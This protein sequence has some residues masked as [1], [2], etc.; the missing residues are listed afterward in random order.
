MTEIAGQREGKAA[1]SK[2]RMAC[3]KN[4]FTSEVQNVRTGND[5]ASGVGALLR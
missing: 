1:D 4:E 5:A 3:G 2:E